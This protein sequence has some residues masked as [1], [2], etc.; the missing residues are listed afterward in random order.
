MDFPWLERTAP[1]ADGE[2]RRVAV[3]KRE[4]ANRAGTLFR[5]GFSEAEAAARLSAR[6]AWE[7]DPPGGFHRRPSE[8]SDQAIAKLVSDTYA[9]RPT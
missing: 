5:L 6:Y 9:R 7:F 4:I 3:A 8:L 2:A 1:H